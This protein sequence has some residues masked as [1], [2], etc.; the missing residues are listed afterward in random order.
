M[1]ELAEVK[2]LLDKVDSRQL[3]EKLG[4]LGHSPPRILH[5]G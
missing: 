5:D 1:L 4:N 3:A 2:P